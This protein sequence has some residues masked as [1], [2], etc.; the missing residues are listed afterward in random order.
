M[1]KRLIGTVGAVVGASVLLAGAVLVTLSACE[2]EGPAETAG[3]KIDNA[4]EKGGEQMEKTDDSIRD[5]TK[6]GNN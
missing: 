1:I 5:A 2:Q 4:V 3:E 6:P